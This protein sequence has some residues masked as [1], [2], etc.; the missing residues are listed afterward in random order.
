MILTTDDLWPPLMIMPIP[1]LLTSMIRNPVKMV[2]PRRQRD[3]GRL[4]GGSAVIPAG[5][6]GWF[7][8]GGYRR[9]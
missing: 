6:W 1:I 2:A 5:G 8:F 3:G 7:G 4:R 9:L